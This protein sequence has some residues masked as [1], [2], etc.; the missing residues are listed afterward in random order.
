MNRGGGTSALRVLPPLAW[1]ALIAWFSTS[2]WSG[3]ET[4]NLL[5][6]LLRWLLPWAGPEQLEALHWLIRKTAH[7]VEYGTLAALWRWALGSGEAW[8]G[9][10]APL[11]L[12][13]LTAAFDELHQSTTFT[14]TGSLADVLLDSAGAGAALIALN[15]GIRSVLPW[16]TGALL[17]VAAAGGTALIALDWRA[18][19]PAGWLWWSVPPAWIALALWLRRRRT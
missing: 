14:R 17:S 9:W 3:A 1:T 7:A 16:L 2:G 5:L 12:S 13:I 10:L 11:G 15:G 18:G 4:G 19:V 8:R 6:P